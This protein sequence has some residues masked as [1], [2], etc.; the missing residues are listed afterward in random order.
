MILGASGSFHSWRA[1]L[2]VCL[3]VLTLC[4]PLMIV[5]ESAGHDAIEWIFSNCCGS[6]DGRVLSHAVL[7]ELVTSE[8]T[9]A[10]DGRCA[11]SCV[12]TL[13]LASAPEPSVP[14]ATHAPLSI[15]RL[16]F[17][18]STP[19]LAEPDGSTTLLSPPPHL[20]SVSEFST[21]LLI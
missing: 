8:R 4:A 20:P 19:H 3:S 18:S 1:A 6:P 13:L 2:V 16:G 21:V 5:C 15:A 7:T 11:D 9:G 10:P 12:D 14:T 17:A